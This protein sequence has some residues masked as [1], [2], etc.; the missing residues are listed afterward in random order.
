MIRFANTLLVAIALLI[1][2]PAAL[3]QSAQGQTYTILHTFTNGPDGGA[4]MTGV[5][6]DRGGNLYG[7][8]TTP[9]SGSVFK[10]ST[11]NVLTTLY[12]FAGGNDGDM[13]DANVVFGPNGILYGTT[14]FGGEVG[15]LP[16]QAISNE[17]HGCGMAFTLRPP[18]EICRTA[19]CP[20]QETIINRFFPVLDY[21]AAPGDGSLVFDQQG[22]IYGATIQ[23]GRSGFGYGTVYELTYSNGGWT[24]TVLYN[25]TDGQDGAYP[26]GVIFDSAGNLY[27][28][29]EGWFDAGTGEDRFGKVFQLVRSGS[30]WSEN[31]FYAFQD[32]ADGAAPEADLVMDQQGNLYGTTS[33]GGAGGGGTVF[34]LSPSGGGWTFKLLYSFSSGCNGSLISEFPPGCG[35]Q[36]SLIIDSAGN[37]YGTAVSTGANGLGSVFELTYPNW[38]YV[39]LHDF[40]GSD[41]QNPYGSLAFGP[42]G[43]LYGTASAGGQ[44]G[45]GVVFQITQ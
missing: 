40:A 22:N 38:T 15:G 6:V 18:A 17:F 36:G 2:L 32:G 43:E 25:F 41:G 23:G 16:C 33:N 3:S 8:T 45:F 35:S 27:G 21:G 29:T 24:E 5:T 37:L 14:E 4:P 39:P 31:F 20:W 12:A 42:N 10:L 9:N 13:P 34:E 30:G 11:H 28:T 19:S 1:A 7:T 26:N 44:D